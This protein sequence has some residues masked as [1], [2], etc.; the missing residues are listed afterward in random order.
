[1]KKF[2]QII[3]GVVVCYLCFAISFF[4]WFA[5]QQERENLKYKAEINQVMQEMKDRGEYYDVDLS[6]FQYLKKVSFLAQEETIDQS[7]VA[8]FYQ[9]RNGVHSNVQLLMIHQQSEGYVRFDYIVENANRH[10]LWFVEGI[11][12]VTTI[13]VI[14]LLFYIHTRILKPFHSLGEMPYELAKGH[15]QGELEENKNRY[16]GR[17]L[18]GLSMLRDT[19]KDAKT[20]EMTLVRDKK[21]LLLSLSHDIKIPLSA[22]KLYTKALRENIYETKEEQTHAAEQIEVHAQEIENF[23]KEII[24]ASS[25]D[26]ISIE[27]ENTEFYL[28]D[29]VEKIR[30]NYEPKCQI[31]MTDFSI[32]EFENRLLKGDMERAFEVMENLLE[33]AFKYGD[34]VRISIDFYEEDY[35]QIIRVFNSGKPISVTELPHLFDSFYRGSNVGSKQGNGLGLYISKQIMQKMDGDIFAERCEDGMNFCL[36]FRL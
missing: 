3:A 9:N 13:F 19:L 12:F 35:C 20:K 31:R 22:I 30:E 33:N 1:M 17:F 14:A 5:R 24:T 10:L 11:L 18:W 21:L 29:Y 2:K 15:L 4:V 34:G 27:V 23:L 36:V 7:K 28:K 26:I 16:F 25:E 32:G 6:N 8:L